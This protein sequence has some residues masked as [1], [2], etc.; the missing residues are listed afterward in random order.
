MPGRLVNL[1]YTRPEASQCVITGSL[2]ASLEISFHLQKTKQKYP[3]QIFGD[4]NICC[5][6]EAVERPQTAGSPHHS[7]GVSTF[8]VCSTGEGE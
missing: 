7:S 8:T 5:V 6:Q 2:S 1:L 3:E 4:E